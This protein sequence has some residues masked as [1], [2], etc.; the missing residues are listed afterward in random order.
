MGSFLDKIIIVSIENDIH[1]KSTFPGFSS[2]SSEGDRKKK[3]A[4]NYELPR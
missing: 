4:K 1:E 2:C 3:S